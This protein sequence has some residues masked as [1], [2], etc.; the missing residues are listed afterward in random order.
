MIKVNN[1]S[2][3]FIKYEKDPGILGMLKAFFKA[4]KVHLK[5]VD[6]INFTINT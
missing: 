4:K 6:N 1:L 2:K 5:A 3:T